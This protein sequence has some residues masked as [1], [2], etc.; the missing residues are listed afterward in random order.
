MR[1]KSYLGFGYLLDLVLSL[2]S[3]LGS[4]VYCLFFIAV[5]LGNLNCFQTI[6]S[7]SYSII[8]LVWNF[9]SDMN[10]FS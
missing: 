9:I 5:V 3:K 6:Y 2:L 8:F 4:R 1:K 7:F 10:F